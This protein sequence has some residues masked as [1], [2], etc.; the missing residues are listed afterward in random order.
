[1]KRVE[2]MIRGRWGVSGF[3]FRVSGFNLWVLPATQNELSSWAPGFGAKD[4]V[5][6]FAVGASRK[7]QKQLQQQPQGPSAKVRP[8]DDTV[9]VMHALTGALNADFYKRS[10]RRSW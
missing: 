7:R 8:Q 1:L 6:D 10:G 2:G 3:G 5:V 9:L 4:L